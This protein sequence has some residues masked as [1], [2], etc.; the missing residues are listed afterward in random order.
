MFYDVYLLIEFDGVKI[1]IKED[2][3]VWFLV[4][5]YDSL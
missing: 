4:G 1:R 5:D 3:F 2:F